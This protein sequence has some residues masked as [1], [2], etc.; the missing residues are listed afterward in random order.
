MTVFS[1]VGFPSEIL[2]DKGTQFMSDLMKEISRLI[3]VKQIYTTAWHP[4]TNGLCEKMNGVLKNMLKKMCDE[5]PHDWD[6]YLP[7]VL[8]AY[9]EVPQES[10]G[11]S[12]VELLYGRQVRGPM[13]ILKKTLDGGERAE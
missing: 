5:R 6:R 4:Q 3:S 1:R 10:T 8:F 13:Q 12:P 9:R 7:A 2:S 11:F